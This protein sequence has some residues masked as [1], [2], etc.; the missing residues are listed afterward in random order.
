MDRTTADGYVIVGGKRRHRD[1][2]LALG[3]Q[4]TVIAAADLDAYQEEILEVITWAGLVP[5][6]ADLTQLR[7]AIALKLALKQDALGFTPVQQ[8]GGANQGANKVYIG[9]GTGGVN[10]L[11]AQ[12]DSTDLGRIWADHDALFGFGSP[13]YIKFP[14]GLILQW[15]RYV[16]VG[17]NHENVVFP[18]AFPNNC[19]AAVACEGAVGGWAPGP[20]PTIFGTA[21]VDRFSFA[22]S[23]VV[24]TGS[25]WT[26]GAGITVSWFAVGS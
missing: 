15:G 23:V 5:N 13:G 7:Q 4:G 14:G 20:T 25:G 16:T 18:L 6:A 10:A 17:G 8:G 1:E 22:T 11:R 24:W 3:I 26:Y 21:M 2:D 19:F 12:V 9:W